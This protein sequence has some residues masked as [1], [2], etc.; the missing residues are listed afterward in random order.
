MKNETQQPGNNTRVSNMDGSLVALINVKKQFEMAGRPIPVLNGINL[1]IRRG[2]FVTLLGKSGSGK[3]TLLN[4]VAGLDHPSSGSV[5]VDGIALEMLG[6]AEL[7]RWRAH[8]VG[9]VFQFFQLLPTLTAFENVMLPMELI[10]SGSSDQR[11]QRARLLLEQ[12]GLLE[13][14]GQ[15][16][17]ALSGG[18]QQRVAIARALANDPPLILA[19][20]PTGNID[21][22]S[23]EVVL[24]VFSQLVQ[25]GRTI[26]MVTHDNYVA[27][28]A[29]RTILL[30]DGAVIS[31]DQRT[32]DSQSETSQA[33]RS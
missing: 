4:L 23:A 24:Q 2:E 7:S 25:Q 19:D 31:E 20:E 10:R 32:K 9:V 30:A 11:R 21:S 6:E 13:Q 15:L 5:K 27:G 17:S 18:Q 8:A 28:H 33:W 22:Q 26:L 12:M 3:S 29:S 1:Q 16:P 14:A